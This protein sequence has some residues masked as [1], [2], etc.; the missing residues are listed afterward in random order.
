MT[1]IAGF[2][3]RSGA[4]KPHP[5]ALS[6]PDAIILAADSEEGGSLIKTSVRKIARIEK[7]GCVCFVGGAGNGDFIDLAVEEAERE[8]LGP[9]NHDGVKATLEKVVT[10]IY[11]ERIDRYPANERDV[12]GFTL[13]CAIWVAGDGARLVKVDRHFSLTLK[14][15]TAI[16]SGTYLARYLFDTLY[17][18]NIAIVTGWRFAAYLVA[19]VKKHVPGCGGTTQAIYLLGDGRWE[20]LYPNTID[21]AETSTAVVMESGAKWLMV[22]ADPWINN[23]DEKKVDEAINA[24]AERVKRDMHEVMKKF[25]PPSTTPQVASAASSNEPASTGSSEAKGPTSSSA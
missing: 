4:L 5:D 1:L 9:F 24:L 2:F 3:A 11:M 17:S 7:P 10:A 15:P 25:K 22:L 6:E 19:Q 8:L 23:W 20:E 21:L 18:D 14:R 13:L 12:L 16:G